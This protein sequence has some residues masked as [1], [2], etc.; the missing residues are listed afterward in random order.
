MSRFKPLSKLPQSGPLHDYKPA[1]AP[2]LLTLAPASNT[3]SVTPIVA[4]HEAS[5]PDR[6]GYVFLCIYFLSG[7]ANEFAMRWLNGKAYLSTASLLLLPLLWLFSRNRFRGM[8]HN[9]GRWWLLFLICMLVDVPFSAWR[10]GSIDLL[11]NYLPRSFSMFFFFTAFLVTVKRCRTIVLVNIVAS[12]IVLLSCVKY[13][14]YAA[15]GRFMLPDSLFFT[16]SNDLALQ[17]LLGITTF[18]FLFYRPGLLKKLFAAIAITA[19][20]MFML[21]TG[22][23]GTMLAAIAYAIML[24]IFSQ[25][26]VFLVAIGMIAMVVGLATLP[27]EAFRRL[28]LLGFDD[29]VE[30]G[31]DVSAVESGMQRKQ[32]VKMSIQKT[33][34]HPLFGVGP[35]QF[36]VSVTGDAAKKGQ[37]S[38]WLGTHN[39][40]TQVSSECGIPAFVAYCAVI[41]LCFRL[42]YRMYRAARY[43][44]AHSDIAALSLTLF[45]G[46]FVYS[47]ATLFFHMAYTS[48]LPT[49]SGLT[50]ALY[51][52]AKPLLAQKPAIQHV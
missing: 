51:L 8:L 50:V 43:N 35:G 29:S 5:A 6:I 39:S 46:T 36:A 28:T 18:V 33:L 52:I 32:L 23:R 26:K 34:T 7:F 42:N 9:T 24:F 20:L 3:A 19:S 12:T 31:I 1:N 27:G 37:W 10:T 22:S 49:L 2:M 25:Q 21:R 38:A 13:G 14:S 41:I 48:N 44:S 45:S 17:L 40:Y 11:V 15:D 30:S 47:I 16:N 4:Q